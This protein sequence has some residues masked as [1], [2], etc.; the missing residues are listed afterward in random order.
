MEATPIMVIALHRSYSVLPTES[1]ELTKNA[2][3]QV[4]VYARLR[5]F[6]I[7]AME[8]NVKTLVK[9][10]PVESMPNVHQ[11]THHN[12]C[13]KQDSKVTHFKAVSMKMVR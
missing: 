12:V 1:V 9:D 4:N 6:W 3:S 2:Y 13:A 7:Q 5:S 11:P 8:T 10:M